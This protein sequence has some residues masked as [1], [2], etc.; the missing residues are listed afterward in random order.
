MPG[1]AGF[2]G[3]GAMGGPMARNLVEH[4]VSLV[5][6]DVDPARAER[7]PTRGATRVGSAADVAAGVER[8]I[9]MVVVEVLER[10]AGVT[11]GRGGA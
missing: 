1:T 3:L 9:S 8:P 10:L 6:H 2:I 7:W 4:G 11:V 5:V